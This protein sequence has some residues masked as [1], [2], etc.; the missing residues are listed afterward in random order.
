MSEVFDFSQTESAKSAE[1]IVPGVYTVTILEAK[2]NKP[3]DKSAFLEL[4]METKEGSK[5]S[6]KMYITP[7]TLGRLQYLHEFYIG[8]K[9]DKVFN[10]VDEI[11]SYFTK[12]FKAEAVKKISRKMII[13][14]QKGK[15]GGVFPQLPYTSFIVDP[16]EDRPEGAF[17]EDSND[18]K[19]YVKEANT[20]SAVKNNDNPMIGSGSIIDDLPF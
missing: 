14:G 3:E 20:A 8:K 9:L 16:N 2:L 19:Q 1:R 4:E 13:G 12:L 18:W 11:G 10:S 5:F 17:I 15:N 6:D 7:K